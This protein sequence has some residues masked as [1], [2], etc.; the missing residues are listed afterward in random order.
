[1]KIIKEYCEHIKIC[2]IRTNT[3]GKSLKLII[4]LYNEALKDFPK[5][6][7]EDVIIIQFSGRH[8]ART[9][10]IEFKVETNVPE[11]YFRIDELEMIY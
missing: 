9:Y 4:D 6:K 2:I 7:Y 11:E 5:L 8:Y 3:Y 10:G 1:M